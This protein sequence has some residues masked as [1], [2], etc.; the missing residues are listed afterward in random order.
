MLLQVCCLCPGLICFGVYWRQ[1]C[2]RTK[3]IVIGC[4]IASVLWSDSAVQY[5]QTLSLMQLGIVLHLGFTEILVR[6]LMHVIVSAMCT[7][8]QFFIVMF[9]WFCFFRTSCVKWCQLNDHRDVKFRCQMGYRYIHCDLLRL[10]VVTVGDCI[11]LFRLKYVM[12]IF[13]A[14][15]SVLDGDVIW[16]LQNKIFVQDIF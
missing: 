3:S 10:T 12:H 1:I 15:K 16:G 6:I 8:V 14:M 9:V 4:Q 5:R 13:V 11:W 7:H 2:I